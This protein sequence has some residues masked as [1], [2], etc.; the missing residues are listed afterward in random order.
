MKLN[1]LVPELGMVEK[2][3]TGPQTYFTLPTLITEPNNNKRK[4]WHK[5]IVVFS[6][7]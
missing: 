6:K 4:Q 3:N 5:V 2:Y 7:Q 1:K